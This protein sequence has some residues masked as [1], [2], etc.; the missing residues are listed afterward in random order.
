MARYSRIKPLDKLLD[1]MIVEFE[2]GADRVHDKDLDEMI[3]ELGDYE[4]EEPLPEASEFKEEVP[5]EEDLVE[6]RMR[7]SRGKVSL[8]NSK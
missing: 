4:N 3:W 2:S 8:Q 1:D 5:I 7:S 6:K